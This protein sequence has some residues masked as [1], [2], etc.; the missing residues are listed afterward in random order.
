MRCYFYN[1]DQNFGDLLTHYLMRRMF[2]VD[3]KV[4][5]PGEAELFG[6][7]SLAA[8]VPDGFSGYILGTGIM[9]EAERHD[10]TSA[11]VLGLRGYRTA[12]RVKYFG[13]PVIGDPGLIIDRFAPKVEKQYDLGIIPHYVD[14]HDDRLKPWASK[15]GVCIIDIQSGVDAV[16]AK[17]AACRTI[18]SSSLHGLVL[19]DSLGIPN[20]WIR[21]S[22]KIGGGNFKFNDYYSAFGIRL[23]PVT[24][25]GYVD[26]WERPGLREIKDRLY[27]MI[28]DFGLSQGWTLK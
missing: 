9:H 4:S 18:V 3:L 28:V 11:K 27:R 1:P 16:I 22:D 7:G 6:I 25:I 17:A 23:E 24:S 12:V 2:G 10:W 14:K 26:L 8:S 13:D 20:Q 15:P 21:L 5:E 19:A